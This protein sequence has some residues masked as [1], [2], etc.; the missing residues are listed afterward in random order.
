MS[1]HTEQAL[2][3]AE[4]T[5][6]EHRFTAEP[7]RPPKKT[8]LVVAVAF[9]VVMAL[10]GVAVFSA[11]AAIRNFQ[12]EREQKRIE[13]E[14][15]AKVEDSRA[16]KVFAAVPPPAPVGEAPAAG[17]DLPTN[18]GAT[19]QGAQTAEPIALRGQTPGGAAPGQGPAGSGNGGPPPVR[20]T[21]MLAGTG[22]GPASPAAPQP[23][24]GSSGQ[25]SAAAGSDYERKMGALLASIEAGQRGGT[26]Q[27]PSATPGG[28]GAIT[29]V[30]GRST[31]QE[32][33]RSNATRNAITT[34]PQATAAN[35]GERSLLMAR[36]AFIPC[37]LETQLFSNVPGPARCVLPEDIYSDDGS[38]VLMQKG[39][40]F[41]GSYSNTLRAGDSRI[42]VI[43]HRYK[44][45]DG[46]V[47]DF[48]SPAADG[49]GTIGVDGYINNH[50]G[51][52]IGAAMLLSLIDDAVS[53]EVAKQSNGAVTT[54]NSS[55]A[56]TTKSMSEQVLNST[57]NI[58][59]T[60]LK[61]RGARLMI[62]VQRDVWFDDVYRLT[63]R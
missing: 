61:N 4:A 62:Y 59:P 16:K 42:A 37:I 28:P 57:I 9:V 36:G 30:L 31:V 18:F 34:T 20:A 1:S 38:T 51:Q 5:G 27:E 44:G 54:S 7:P 46:V 15:R 3:Q 13:R 10:I 23:V 32:F 58:P 33:A 50:W 24:A 49:V 60:I 22:P 43:W 56:N 35:L 19:P 14:Q 2:P 55:T 25:E 11:K 48:E 45:T 47:A 40:T 26:P 17:T 52:R 39:S 63:K 29:R 6:D 53:I 41:S 21:M 12:A 8:A